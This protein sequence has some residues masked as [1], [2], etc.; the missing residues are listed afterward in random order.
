MK[1]LPDNMTM[2]E[3]YG[4]AMKITDPK[5]AEEYL[6]ALIERNMRLSGHSRE[7]AEKIEKGNLGYYAGYYNSATRERVER[8]FNCSHPV[9]GSIAEKGNPTP[10]EAL[11]AGLKMGQKIKK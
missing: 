5:E 7:E 6:S 9:F 8:L 1:A 3:A 11:K 4:R 2:G 10:E